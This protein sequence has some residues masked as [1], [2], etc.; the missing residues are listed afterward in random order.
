MSEKQQCKVCGCT[1]DNPCIHPDFGACFWIKPDL[2]SHCV[3]LKDDPRVTRP[4][5]MK[6]MKTGI[7]KIESGECELKGKTPMACMFCEFGHMTECHY[8]LTC[9]EAECLH[10]QSEMEALDD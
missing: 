1:E 10:F 9:E 3:E 8:P 2:C 7:E 4:K 6:P 5:D